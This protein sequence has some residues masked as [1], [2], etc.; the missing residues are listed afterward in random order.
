[1]DR[2][3]N[4]G[5]AEAVETMKGHQNLGYDN[6]QMAHHA[7]NAEMLSDAYYK[8]MHEQEKDIVYFPVDSAPV[9]QTMKKVKSATDDANYKAGYEEMKKSNQLNLCETPT[10]KTAQDVRGKTSNKAYTKEHEETKFKVNPPPVT[11]EMIQSQKQQAVLTQKAYTKEGM[12]AL[13]SYNNDAGMLNRG[14]IQQAQKTQKVDDHLKLEYKKDYEQ[15]KTKYEFEKALNDV[16]VIKQNILASK[17][18]D[19]TNSTYGAGGKN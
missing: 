14:D 16:P 3:Y 19:A 6:P 12:D 5:K 17:Q 9:Y 18:S 13:R 7:K 10:Y 11:H 4:K 15:N 8:E 2:N 1:M